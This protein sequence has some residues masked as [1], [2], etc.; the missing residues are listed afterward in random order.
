MKPQA[1]VTT[2]LNVYK[3]VM[4]RERKHFESELVSKN[5]QVEEAI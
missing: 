2:N 5:G 3:Q 4:E 1:T